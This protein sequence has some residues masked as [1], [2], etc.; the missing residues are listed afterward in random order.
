MPRIPLRL[1]AVC[2]PLTLTLAS[3]P[4]V[5]AQ[6][7]TFPTD[8]PVLPP[9]LLTLLGGGS[10][11]AAQ[12][13][14]LLVVSPAQFFSPA[15]ALPLGGKPAS[16]LRISEALGGQRRIVRIGGI[17]ALVPK[18]MTVINTHP[19]KANA[20]AGLKAGETVKLLLATLTPAQWDL[21]GGAGGLG[22]SDL[23]E[24]QRTLWESLMP[25]QMLIQKSS[26]VPGEKPGSWVFSDSTQIPVANPSAVR[27]RINKKT[28]WMFSKSGQ[29]DY[30]YGGSPPEGT[31]EGRKTDYMLLSVAALPDG[32][33]R[34]SGGLEP[35]TSR[36][37]NQ[38]YGVAL[39]A[40]APNR[41]KAGAVDFASPTLDPRISLAFAPRPVAPSAASDPQ[42][43][44][45]RQASA[46]PTVGDLF[47]RVTAATG[48]VFVADRR[49]RD[50]PV[51]VAG[52][53]ARA[54]DVLQALALSLTGAFRKIG[55]DAY[56]GAGAKPFYLLTADTAGVGAEVARL[57]EWA[58][59][60]E[61]TKRRVMDASHAA[62]A[63][64][65]PLSHLHFAP[66]DPYAPTDAQARRAEEGWRKEKYA[67]RPR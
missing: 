17:T 32:G 31:P 50:Q 67:S 25:E 34:I 40:D 47:S 52:A 51:F 26:A 27:L 63:K 59:D 13:G 6:M 37:P 44:L 29:D 53:G 61:S 43:E 49:V 35:K 54:G 36:D 5:R 10:Y 55:T 11:D 58:E 4:A 28:N 24:D 33:T 12:S 39:L 20:F 64:N 2:F 56:T 7:P 18:L 14:P 3:A 41:L 38:V 62:A 22:A 65:D 15:V 9:N 8:A 19:G 60:A 57:A 23:T 21:V 16:L 42:A 48:F 30:S 1:L 66:G 45:A 46:L